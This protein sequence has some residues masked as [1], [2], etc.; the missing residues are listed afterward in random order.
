MKPTQFEKTG[1][2]NKKN[3]GNLNLKI[4]FQYW[5]CRSQ[6]FISCSS[7]VKIIFTLETIHILCAQF[8]FF[9]C[10]RAVLSTKKLNGVKKGTRIAGYS[11]SS[12]E[13]PTT[14]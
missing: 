7:T 6:N 4:H 14:V 2:L 9:L 10:Q 1:V 11:A 3:P 5:T 12:T 8:G 13:F